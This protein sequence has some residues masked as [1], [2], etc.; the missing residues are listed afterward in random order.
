MCICVCVSRDIITIASREAYSISLLLSAI[1]RPRKS[2]VAA[3]SEREKRG[4]YRPTV[5]RETQLGRDYRGS[6]CASNN[7]P[8]YDRG[9]P[10]V[11]RPFRRSF[12]R[13]FLDVIEKFCDDKCAGA[14]DSDYA[15]SRCSIRLTLRGAPAREPTSRYRR[16]DSRVR[17]RHNTVE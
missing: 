7:R 9:C 6:L 4:T 10:V 14:D 5:E 2:F 16:A 17:G 11:R 3:R 1:Y 13:I 8:L 12:P 15:R